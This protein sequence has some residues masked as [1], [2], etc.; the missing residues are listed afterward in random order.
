[1]CS[2]IDLENAIYEEKLLCT[3]IHEVIDV[4]LKVQ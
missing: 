4:V 1:M 3:K 2:L